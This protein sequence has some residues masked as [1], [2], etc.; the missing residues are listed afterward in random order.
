MHEA[1]LGEALLQTSLNG[2]DGTAIHNIMSL[3]GTVVNCKL[4]VQAEEQADEGKPEAKQG[5]EAA[6]GNGLNPASSVDGPSDSGL[7]KLDADK[8]EDS[9]PVE[10]KIEA[11]AGAIGTQDDQSEESKVGFTLHSLFVLFVKYEERQ[12]IRNLSKILWESSF[13]LVLHCQA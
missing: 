2:Q 11:V 8:E 10:D 5:S 9:T 12:L 4:Q 6:S 3:R 1:R 13:D 7:A